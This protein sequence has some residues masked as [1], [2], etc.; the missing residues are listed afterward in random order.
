VRAA[1]GVVS[2]WLTPRDHAA[3]P[4]PSRDDP[5][6]FAPGASSS[7][8]VARLIGQVTALTK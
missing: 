6:F 3:S 1:G 7:D 8:C 2:I 4:N 5:P